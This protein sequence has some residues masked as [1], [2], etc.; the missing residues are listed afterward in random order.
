MKELFPTAN[1]SNGWLDAL[2]P[3][4]NKIAHGV[5]AGMK[6]AFGAS[7][8]V[9]AD[10]WFSLETGPWMGTF[11]AAG[12]SG[13]G[14]GGG[15]GGI[16][17][18]ATSSAVSIDGAA[19]TVGD[20]GCL[21]GFQIPSEEEAFTRAQAVFA[22]LADA[23]P[24]ATWIYQGYPWFRVYSQG[25]QCD[26]PALRAF[27]KGFTRAIPKDRLLVLDLIA[28]RP[29]GQSALWSYPDDPQL[30]KF[31]QNAS[32]IW[33][34]LNNWGGAVNMGGDLSFVLNQTRE[35]MATPEV[36]GVGLTPEGIDNSPAYFSLVLDSPWTPQPT[37]ESWYQ[38]WGASRCGASGVK[39]AEKAYELLFETVYKPDQPYLWCCSQPVWC[40]TT[41][42]GGKPAQPYY[43]TTLLRQ[44]LELM[45]EA[46]PS[47]D[48][49]AFKY[50]LVDVARQWLSMAPCLDAFDKVDASSGGAK[51]KLV[52]QTAA[53]M[54]VMSD[55]DTMMMTDPGFLLG[56]WLQKS[57]NVSTWDGSE[58]KLADFYEYNS[59]MQITTWAG[60][61][62]RREWSGM[63]KQYYG[64]RLSI[65]LDHQLSQSSAAVPAAIAVAPHEPSA[66][67]HAA[68]TAYTEVPD[69]DCNFEDIGKALKCPAS[70]DSGGTASGPNVLVEN[71]AEDPSA[72]I[73]F[74]EEACN[75]ESE[76]VGFNYPG[77]ILKHGC[78]GWE[79]SP[80]SHFYFK[81]GHSPPAPPRSS[82]VN[83][84][85]KANVGVNGT[86][87]GSSCSGTCPVPTPLPQLL[88]DFA[89]KWNNATWSIDDVDLPAEPQG[90]PVATA[91]AMLAKYPG[92]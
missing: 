54:S 13:G 31:T 1:T 48:T 5:G 51:D 9:E 16:D 20:G 68:P 79:P 7:S 70:N 60:A 91:R 11:D 30:G 71:G 90:D 66:S 72:C 46:A 3:L 86:F 2:D 19:E 82:C 23:E 59:R 4:F 77:M 75:A 21:N 37:A 6:E 89:D 76:C 67:L 41:L 32:L 15:G 44:A 27:I 74:L 47:C 25:K 50:D 24:N 63:I 81:P 64:G 42:P 56:S 26:Q 87:P 88:S 62:S 10:G 92:L 17:T 38:E 39:A 45:V 34:A 84:V 69:F 18:A 22:S 52:E 53:L 85:C 73:A 12:G 35:A 28:D 8:F 61:Y 78:S 65:W 58:G 40:P 36:Q 49:A 55:I 83:G 14:G 57:R 43:N 29:G 80:N 33:C